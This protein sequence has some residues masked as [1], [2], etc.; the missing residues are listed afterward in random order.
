M[1]PTISLSMIVKNEEKYLRGCLESVKNY[2]DEIIIVD[3]GSTDKSIEIAEE[4]GAKIFHFNWT[5][6]F[7]EARNESLK[8]CTSDWILYLDAD[9]RLQNG[10]GFTLRSIIEN[11]SAWGYTLLIKGKHHLPSGVVEQV[12]AYPRMFRNHP[13]IYFEGV[14]HE[15]IQ[16]SILRLGPPRRILSSDIAIEH[17]GYGESLEKIK[18]KSLRNVELLKHQL[19]Q[20]P[21]DDYARY[22]LGNTYVVLQD[23]TL[24]E[25]LLRQA[26]QSKII[27]RGIK[28]TICNLLVEVELSE[29]KI[30]AGEAWCLKSID[31]TPTQTMAR[32]FLSGILAHQ[33]KYVQALEILKQLKNKNNDTT[34][35][36]HDLVL[37]SQQIDE[38]MIYCYEML[39]QDAESRSQTTMVEQWVNDAEK[40]NIRSYNLQRK[41]LELSLAKK[42]ITTAFSRLEYVVDNLPPQANS[43][44]AKFESIKAKL[45]QYVASE[46]SF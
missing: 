19:L 1:K 36:A 35:L 24:A 13:K 39:V 22:Q 12:N 11:T 45:E 40:D 23:Y 29:H 9:E 2:V 46:L 27:D 6:N 14:V 5:G 44:K 31:Y 25:P 4:F 41:G 18:E 32:W 8:H 10:D 34:L 37:S 20:H 43:Q 17:L 21:N 7:S 3:T 26:L 28:S 15:Q 38:R 16:P 33:K 42:D 30:E